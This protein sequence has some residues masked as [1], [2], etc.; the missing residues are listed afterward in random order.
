M[1]KVMVVIRIMPE[2]TEVNLKELEKKI[3]EEVKNFGGDVTRV[4]VVPIAFGLSALD[5][6]FFM[7]EKL[8]ATDPLEEKLANIEGVAS[9][10]TTDVRRVVG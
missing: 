3:K 10:S 1:A 2:G 5:I 8:G 4:T 7:D 6:E 9:A